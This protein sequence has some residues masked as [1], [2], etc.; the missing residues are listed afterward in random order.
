MTEHPILVLGGTGK[1]GR[2]VAAHLRER[3]AAVRA[4]SRSTEQRFD[5]HDD[6]TWDAALRGVRAVYLVEPGTADAPETVRAFARR[7]AARGAERLVLLSFRSVD[8]PA[9]GHYQAIERAVRDAGTGWTMLRPDWFAQNF[10]EDFF[11]RGVLAGELRLPTGD[12]AVPFIDA[13]DIAAVAAAVLTEDG[14]DG[15]HY[16]LT[17]PRALTVAEALAEIA[18][19]GGPAARYAHVD[20]A[21]FT[22]ELGR[23]GWPAE[24]AAVVTTMLDDI[25]QGHNAP[26]SDGVRQVLGRE[27]VDFTRYAEAAAAAGAWREPSPGRG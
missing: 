2:R 6:A 13:E 8:A 16:D 4:V 23:Q 1:T 5:W 9:Y 27:P 11:R 10:T 26:L 25:R 7:A 24:A 19:A 18:R 17:G 3:G 12:G 20:A 22:A 15:R 21:A 14:H